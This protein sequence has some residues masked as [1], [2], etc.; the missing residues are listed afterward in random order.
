MSQLLHDQRRLPIYRNSGPGAAIIYLQ[1]EPVPGW[2][3]RGALV[4]RTMMYLPG[5][6]SMEDRVVLQR[7]PL[8]TDVRYGVGQLKVE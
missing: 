7:I 2:H 6:R 3:L 8:A 4:A 1:S 5:I